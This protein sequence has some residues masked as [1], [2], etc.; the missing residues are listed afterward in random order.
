MAD[1]T[2]E[3]AIQQNIRNQF[4][5]LIPEEH[6]RELVKAEIDK[7]FSMPVPQD[8]SKV[9]YTPFGWL[10][11]Q[12]LMADIKAKIMVEL[13]SPEY[14]LVWDSSGKPKVHESLKKIIVDNSGEILMNIL[15]GASQES[16][17]QLKF[18]I[19]NGNVRQ[20][21]NLPSPTY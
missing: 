17:T 11:H 18:A 4:A 13:S 19:Q 9:S 6:F 3:Q 12:S 1:T 14:Q 8:V 2:L 15:A 5:E 16:I 10:V 7:F 20:I 21:Y